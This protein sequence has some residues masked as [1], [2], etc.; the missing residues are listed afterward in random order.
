M[1]KPNIQRIG[2][3]GADTNRVT[4]TGRVH[5]QPELRLIPPGTTLY[6]LVPLLV[7]GVWPDHTG[8]CAPIDYEI[9]CF[10][11]GPAAEK[12]SWLTA[13]DQIQV[14]GAIDFI[15]GEWNAGTGQVACVQSIRVSDVTLLQKG[16]R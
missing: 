4:L 3:T 10:A 1:G 8:Q 14:Y 13:G 11:Q 6:L 9:T 15:V 7:R 2:Y 16:V 12:Y 5:R